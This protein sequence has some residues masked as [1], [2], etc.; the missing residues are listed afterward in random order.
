L[1]AIFLKWFEQCN[2]AAK[3]KAIQDGHCENS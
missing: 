1:S 2:S 3:E